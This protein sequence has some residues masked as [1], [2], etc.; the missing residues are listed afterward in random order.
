MLLAALVLVAG[1][2][3][4]KPAEQIHTYSIPKEAEEAPPPELPAGRM[5]GAI[6]VQPTQGW[7]FKLMGPSEAVTQHEA[8]FQAFLK[9]LRF[10]GD[11]PPRWEAPAGWREEPGGAMRFATFVIEA[12]P[13]PLELTVTTL[14]H[15]GEAEADYVLKNVNRWR[16]QIQLPPIGPEQLAGETSRVELDGI[17]AT[18]VNIEGKL[19][20]SS[21][22]SPPVA[23]GGRNGK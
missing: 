23:P 20:P 12:A 13:K 9:S 1:S 10:T 15:A 7:F 16:N 5:L 3:G 17:T 2:G 22:G 21:M 6:V 4:C 11:G 19:A 8:E 18:T 14:P